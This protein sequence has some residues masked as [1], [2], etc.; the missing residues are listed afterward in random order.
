MVWRLLSFGPELGSWELLGEPIPPERLK[1]VDV[2][3][4]ILSGNGSGEQLSFDCS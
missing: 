2:H 1:L 4:L 3:C